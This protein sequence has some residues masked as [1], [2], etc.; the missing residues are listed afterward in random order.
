MS[1]NNPSRSQGTNRRQFMADTAK[2]AC[3]VGAFGLG[4]GLY[5]NSAKSKSATDLRPPGAGP[6][7]EFLGACI[8]CGLCVRDCPWGTLRL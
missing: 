4:L 3:G 5:A 8:R 7:D 1:T 2:A 6:E